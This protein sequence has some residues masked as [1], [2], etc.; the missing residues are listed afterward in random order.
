MGQ[1]EVIIGSSVMVGAVAR[2]RR[3]AVGQRRGPIRNRRIFVI[4]GA[5]AA[6][7]SGGAGWRRMGR[8]H[9]LPWKPPSKRWAG[10]PSRTCRPLACPSTWAPTGSICQAC[11]RC[12]ALARKRVSEHLP[13]LPTSRG[14]SSTAVKDRTMNMVPG[15][16]RRAGAGGAG[17]SRQGGQ[18]GA[19]VP[20][21]NVLPGSALG[22][23]PPNWSWARSRCARELNHIPPPP[24]FLLDFRAR[25]KRNGG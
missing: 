25:K 12:H 8:L 21:S 2:W 1:E 3:R 23:I 16:R 10:A 13:A 19:D 22:E 9:A 14:S 5:G 6:G 24:P 15:L 4:I 17:R 11:I 18:R 7:I 20:A